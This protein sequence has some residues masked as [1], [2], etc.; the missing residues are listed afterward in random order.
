METGLNF[1]IFLFV[2][3]LHIATIS[4]RYKVLKLVFCAEKLRKCEKAE[5]AC[6]N[7][8]LFIKLISM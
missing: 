1:I 3:K 2:W 5:N 8:C 7:I 6:N 4:I